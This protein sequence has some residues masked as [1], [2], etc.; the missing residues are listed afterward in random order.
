MAEHAPLRIGVIAGDGIGPEVI[1]A[2]QEVIA[3]AGVDLH[4][5]DIPVS[6]RRYLRD[7][8]LLTDE[9]LEQIS[10]VHAVLLG[11]VGDPQVQ[12]GILE[13]E[14]L[15]RL[16]FS[17]DLALNI[18]PVRLLPGATTPLAG[19]TPERVDMIF[20]RENTEGPY[21]GTGGRFRRGTRSEVALQ[22]SVNTDTGVRRAVRHAFGL[23]QSRRLHLTWI[24]KTNV[25]RHAGGL[26]EDVISDVS[27]DFPEVTVDYQHADAA[28]IHL[29]HRPE[30]YDV[31]V[32]DNLFGDLLT[33][34][35]GAIGGGVG[36]MPSANLSV[37]GRSPGIFEPIHG[38]APDIAGQGVANPIGAVLAGALMLD[39]LGLAE[40]AVR[41]T[42]GVT[43]AAT[44]GV[45]R[46]TTRHITDAIIHCLTPRV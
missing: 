2:T 33:D 24:H 28:C 31:V 3:A 14:V 6:A 43:D 27:A 11:A 7:G 32:T 18:R 9:D 16:R 10:S 12:S 29:L 34:L 13:R 8:L 36:L 4:Y 39:D 30:S 1:A 20:V 5:V 40:D 23:A 44:A 25:L 15:L 35:A 19:V 26:W 38:S 17:L 22:D 41:I 46:G 37:D 42:G 21:A 45:L